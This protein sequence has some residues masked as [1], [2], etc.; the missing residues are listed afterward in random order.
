MKQQTVRSLVSCAGIGVHS[1]KS[2][3]I[4]I[5][6]A[7]ANTGIVFQRADL[8]GENTKIP[9]TWDSVTETRMCTKIDNG[10]GASVSTI[11]H[12]MAALFAC[13]VDNC[14]VRVYGEEVPIMDGSAAPFIFLMECAGYAVQNAPRQFIKI[15]EEVTVSLDKDRWVTLSPTDEACLTID[16]KFDFAGR[17]NFDLQSAV[18]SGNSEQFRSAFSFARTFGFVSDLE[19]L[20][21]MGVAKGASLDNSIG[22]DGERVLA[23]NGLRYHNEFVRHKILDCAGDLYTAGLPLFGK[24]TAYNGGHHLNNL[25]LRALF[26]NESAYEIVTH[27]TGTAG[28]ASLRSLAGSSEAALAHMNAA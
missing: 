24:V 26:E 7:P 1:G 27:A 17:N 14:I 3:K 20:Q 15:R 22:L 25:A 28:F 21:A 11:E 8:S 2:I 18:F 4:E 13:A 12:L 6:P 23:K 9:A 16:F 5:V 10:L 19:K